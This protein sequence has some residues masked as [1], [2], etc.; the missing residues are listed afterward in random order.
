MVFYFNYSVLRFSVYYLSLF[1]RFV[2]LPF[3]MAV[4]RG[5]PPGRSQRFFFFIFSFL[6]SVVGIL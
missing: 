3:R 6:E 4:E 1:F 5:L 2:L